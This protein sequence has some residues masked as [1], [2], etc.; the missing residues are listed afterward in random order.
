MKKNFGTKL[1]IFV[2][3]AFIA[4]LGLLYVFMPKREFSETEKR[5]LAQAPK[6]LAL[7]IHVGDETPRQAE[8]REEALPTGGLQG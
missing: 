6:L 7:Q 3:T 2:F 8:H 5:Y 1:I 4:I